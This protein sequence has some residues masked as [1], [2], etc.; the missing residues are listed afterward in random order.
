MA[1]KLERL[2]ARYKERG[3]LAIV[4]Y[5]YLRVGMVM[6][7]VA[8]A[9]A[10]LYEHSKTDPHCWQT[11]I[12]A[13]YYTPARAI[14]V[15]GLIAIGASLIM[16]KGNNVFEDTFL[17]LAGFF[18]PIV[19]VVPTEAVK[20][21]ANGLLVCKPSVEELRQIRDAGEA[22]TLAAWVRANI[23]NNISTLLIVGLVGLV[24]ASGLAFLPERDR[25]SAIKRNPGGVFSGLVAAG[26][27]LLLVLL[28]R[29]HWG[30][31]Y[32]RA[33]GFA[34]GAMFVFL[35]LA[36]LCNALERR[37]AAQ[38]V[39]SG[40]YLGIFGLMVVLGLYFQVL[41]MSRH[42]VLKVEVAE[43]AL[44]ASFWAV[45]TFDRWKDTPCTSEPREKTVPIKR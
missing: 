9:T 38:R 7:V 19:A 37:R 22:D 11:S 29:V 8:L 35:G 2:N 42:H 39:R 3:D 43:I 20:V 17:N 13:Y 1:S 6:V 24:V 10:V 26:G 18:A 27:L 31:F 15:G 44:F 5:R 41:D 4:T 34:A 40:I 28:A 14:F 25:P 12:S 32:T 45:Q 16:I 30:G 21:N 23:D 33:H 36:V